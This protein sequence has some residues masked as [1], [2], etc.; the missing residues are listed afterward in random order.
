MSQT[1]TTPM[2]VL[3]ISHG[4]PT[5]AFDDVPARDFLVRLG[6]KLPRP[7]GILCISAHW[8]AAVPSVTGSETPST[9]HDFYGFPQALYDLRYDAPGD[10]ALAARV[11]VL[12]EAGGYKPQTSSD[13]GL[14]HGVWSPL[15]LAYPQSG[16]PVV[17][18]S[19]M[20][21]RT[22]ADHVALGRLLAPLREEGVLI[23]ASGGAVH[24]LRALDWNNRTGIT[25][26]AD[27]FDQW[28]GDKI[29]AGDLDAL[30]D[31]RAQAPN[32]TAAHPSEDHI[33]PLFVALGAAAGKDA[34]APGKQLHRSFTFGSLSMSSY[35]W[36]A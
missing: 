17:Q 30:S 15:I 1:A 23:V 25:E 36:E 35:G 3:F 33:M 34:T 9:I 5:L 27:V 2:P 22:P 7:K 10:P 28:L 11:V 20:H 14:D 13:R 4:S 19:L 6:A 18:L 26:W 31:Y 8:E 29:A 21:N 32:A 12:L 16:I 24:N